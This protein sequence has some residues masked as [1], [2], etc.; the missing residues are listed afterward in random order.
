MPNLHPEK[1]S[2]LLIRGQFDSDIVTLELPQRTTASNSSQIDE[3]INYRLLHR[4]TGLDDEAFFHPDGKGMAMVSNRT[5][6]AQVWRF[7]SN[8]GS[9]SGSVLSDFPKDSYIESMLWDDKGEKFMVLAVSQLYLLSK[10]SQMKYLDFNFPITKLFHWDS[11]QRRLLALALIQGKKRFVSLNLDTMEHKII[12]NKNVHWATQTENGTVIF[13]DGQD[14]FWTQGPV[15]DRPISELT[16]KGWAKMRFVVQ[17][18]TIYSVSRNNQLWSF[19][20]VSKEF[21]TIGSTSD[22]LS[23]LTDI[24]DNQILARILVVERKEVIELDIVR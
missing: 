23:Y 6:V 18:D 21:T 14:R 13:I 11:E 3:T 17:N 16:N 2:M 8:D 5:G 20:L 24:Q 1:D 7:A 12:N 19:D 9:D 4:S 10:R 22:D 15:E